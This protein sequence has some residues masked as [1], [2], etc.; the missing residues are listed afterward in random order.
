MLT[1][2]KQS[3]VFALPL[4]II[5]IANVV[6]A[7]R[8]AIFIAGSGPAGDNRVTNSLNSILFWGAI[9]A[10]LGFLGQY[11]GI[12]NA[13]GAI[14]QAPEIS[15]SVVMMGF[16]ESFSTV[17]WGLNLLVFSSVVR[18]ILQGWYHKKAS[19]STPAPASPAS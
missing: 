14:I 11:T 17:L 6:I 7:V 8:C 13:L 2:F 16:R 18:A 1:I 10:V 19:A 5:T 12:Y 9:G 15:P 4:L 3:G